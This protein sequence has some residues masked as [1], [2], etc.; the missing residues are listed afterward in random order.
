MGEI[1]ELKKLPLFYSD[2]FIYEDIGTD[3]QRE[4]LKKQILHA[5]ENKI[6]EV[7][8]SNPNCWRSDAKYDCEWLHDAIYKLSDEVNNIY[9]E[10]EP[11]YKVL[12]EKCTNRDFNYWTNVNEVG[13]K[14]DLHSHTE[15]AWACIYYVQAEGTGNLMFHNPANVLQQCNPHSPFT[16]KTGIMPKDG[17]LILW[18]GW[19]PHEVEENKSNQQRINLAWGIKFR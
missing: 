13:S 3:E 16:R 14:N 15:D 7:G 18:P 11:I 19:V 17:M 1:M 2:V 8:G 5:K 9:F 4:D 12:L 6:G 10:S